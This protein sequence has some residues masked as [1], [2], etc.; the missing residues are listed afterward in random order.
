MV[1]LDALVEHANPTI[2]GEPA[3]QPFNFYADNQW[4]MFPRLGL[5]LEV[6]ALWHQMAPS[7]DLSPYISVDVPAIWTFDDYIHGH[8]PAVDP[9]LSG[10]DMRSIPNIA[11]SEGGDVARVAYRTR[12]AAAESFEWWSPPEEIVLRRVC[13]QLI[14]EERF[15]EAVQTCLLNSEIHPTVWNTWYN[16]AGSLR[17]AGRAEERWSP[18][19]CV[20]EMAPTNWNVPD[21]LAAM[22]N[23]GLNVED[24]LLPEGCPSVD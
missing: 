24:I 9:I 19:R 13:D 18:Y 3:G 12:L 8:D 4:R 16:L 1:V 2:I 20:T 6:S 22:E 23:A 17:D 5:K 14:R 15:E 21:I 11:L 7:D 10:D